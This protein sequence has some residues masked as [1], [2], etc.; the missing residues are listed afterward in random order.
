MKYHPLIYLAFM[1]GMAV[2]LAGM[3]LGLAGCAAPRS[4]A[5]PECTRLCRRCLHRQEGPYETFDRCSECLY[6]L[7]LPRREQHTEPASE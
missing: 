3:L 6:M 5:R 7:P 2:I 1:L 4:S